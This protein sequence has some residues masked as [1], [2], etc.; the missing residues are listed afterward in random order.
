MGKLRTRRIKHRNLWISVY[1]DDQGFASN[2]A[3][4]I[5]KSKRAQNDWH[6]NRKNRRARRAGQLHNKADL[7]SWAACARL[8]RIVLNSH[9]GHIYVYPASSSRKVLAKYLIR[10]GF[11]YSDGFWVRV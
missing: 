6:S 2:L 9:E 10:W 1:L 8:I 11:T 3:L 4:N 7:S 5:Y